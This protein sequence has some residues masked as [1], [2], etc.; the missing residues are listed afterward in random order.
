MNEKTINQIKSL[1]ETLKQAEV[2]HGCKILYAA[3]Y[4]SRAYGTSTPNSDW[5]AHFVF[6]F[7]E[8][9]YLH[10][11]EPP[12]HLDLGNDIVGWELR[13]FMRMLKKSAYSAHELLN[14]PRI[15]IGAENRITLM[16]LANLYYNP[17]SLILAH[18]GYGR[19][20]REK[21][22]KSTDLSHKI[23]YAL[24]Y[25]RMYMTAAVV[26]SRINTDKELVYPSV[27]MSQL[28][29]EY[30]H[31]I[32]E[33]NDPAEEEML[34]K[35][36]GLIRARYLDDGNSE[37]DMELYADHGIAQDVISF[38][39]NKLNALFEK[40][41]TEKYELKDADEDRINAFLVTTIKN[42]DLRQ[43]EESLSIE[44]GD[45]FRLNSSNGHTYVMQVVNINEFR[46]P[47]N[48]YALDVFDETA[49]AWSPDLHFC[50][51]AFLAK[52]KK[53][54]RKEFKERPKNS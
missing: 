3:V 26:A 44:V 38:Y 4:G 14:S 50:D 37:A 31:A 40:H 25:T 30:R 51:S 1:I 19:R 34:R 23:K 53:I 45:T 36:R 2:T 13:A 12:A 27:S 6:A 18:G 17:I 7:H 33:H 32:S 11:Q 9:R 28:I 29:S 5:D 41:K 48:R 42:V 21:Y 43:V 47:A 39:E 54:S 15:L 22:D 20:E 10:L 52:C 24:S 46:D 16:R 35:V 49:K 8:T